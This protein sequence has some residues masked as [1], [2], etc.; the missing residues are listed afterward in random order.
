MK[1]KLQENLIKYNSQVAAANKREEASFARIRGS[2][3]RQE[4]KLAQIKTIAS[5]GTTL[6][7][8]NQGNLLE[9]QSYNQGSIWINIG[10]GLSGTTNGGA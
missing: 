10:T 2:M 6:M 4:A 5:A 8:M 9:H 7:T 1:A 3:A